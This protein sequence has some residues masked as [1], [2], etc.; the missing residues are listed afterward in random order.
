[1]Q[2]KSIQNSE[3]CTEQ[4]DDDTDHSTTVMKA[5][6][7]HD[8]YSHSSFYGERRLSG[9]IAKLSED[10]MERE[11]QRNIIGDRVRRLRESLLTSRRINEHA[12]EEEEQRDDVATRI[13][14]TTKSARLLAE[15]GRVNPFIPRLPDNPEKPPTISL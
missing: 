8:E 9:D 10:L 7:S 14:P 12:L 5:S 4:R 3:A 1:M 11:V 6:T 13:P 2:I 15:V